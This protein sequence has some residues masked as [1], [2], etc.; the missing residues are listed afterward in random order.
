MAGCSLSLSVGIGTG[1]GTGTG[2]PRSRGP[3]VPRSRGPELPL[4]LSKTPRGSRMAIRTAV[5]TFVNSLVII[6]VACCSAV[7]PRCN[8]GVIGLCF[9]ATAQ[10]VR[11]VACGSILCVVGVMSLTS[12][13]CFVVV[14]PSRGEQTP[15]SWQSDSNL[16]CGEARNS[17]T[18]SQIEHVSSSTHHCV[19]LAISKFILYKLISSGF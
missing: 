6:I 9:D 10:V 8:Q 3:E 15:W 5:T 1:T 2:T 4:W 11:R 14:C 7:M 16:V 19:V 12:V 13:S 18:T 17:C